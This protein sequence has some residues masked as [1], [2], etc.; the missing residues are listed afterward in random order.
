MKLVLFS[1]LLLLG[2]AQVQAQSTYLHL[3]EDEMLDILKDREQVGAKIIS[4][5]DAAEATNSVPERLSLL[6][7]ILIL[8]PYS[9]G[10]QC[11]MS[12]VYN[13]LS[14]LVMEVD[15]RQEGLRMA[16]AAL[17]R[18]LACGKNSEIIYNYIGRLGAFHLISGNLDS[19]LHYF[20]EAAAFADT[21]RNPI[22]AASALN[23]LGMVWMENGQM[24]SAYSYYNRCIFGLNPAEPR[25]QNFMGAVTDNLAIWHGLNNEHKVELQLY[26]ENV[27]RFRKF[28]D[29]LR[30]VLSML[31]KADAQWALKETKQMRITLDSA[32]YQLGLLNEQ[33]SYYSRLKLRYHLL[34]K[35]LA[36]L[37][38][39]MKQA[40]V[41]ADNA[42]VWQHKVDSLRSEPKKLMIGALN[43]TE[44]TRRNMEVRLRNELA[45]AEYQLDRRL[46][47]LIAV[48]SFALILVMFVCIYLTRKGKAS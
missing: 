16:H 33:G 31:G 15:A 37:E 29:T 3:T 4:L 14:E 34:D 39:N 19:S 48:T 18:A 41:A 9:I 11:E 28:G 8:E 6:Q 40:L 22:W 10:L 17:N 42:L 38:G 47:I 12:K 46:Y 32:N 43:S 24:D 13:D 35:K 2:V 26:T 20:R 5:K 30:V 1:I 23:N 27:Q 45:E 7:T 36:A 21:L 44:I 25:D